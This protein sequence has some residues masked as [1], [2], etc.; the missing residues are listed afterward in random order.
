[1]LV[2]PHPVVG[3][4]KGL[5]KG[6]IPDAIPRLL[7]RMGAEA[8]WLLPLLAAWAFLEATLIAARVTA[9]RGRPVAE[10]PAARRAA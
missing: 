5:W 1:M 2:K 6:T 7:E 10:R 4:L 8:W 9:S 3:V